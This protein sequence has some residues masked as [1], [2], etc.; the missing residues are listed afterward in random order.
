MQ[1]DEFSESYLETV[2]CAKESV[3]YLT[4]SLREISQMSKMLSLS[5]DLVSSHCLCVRACVCLVHWN[6][7]RVL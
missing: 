5:F 1:G 3:V 6:T 4:C 2:V 7:F